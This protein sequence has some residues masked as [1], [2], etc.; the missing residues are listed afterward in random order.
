MSEILKIELN[1][2]YESVLLVKNLTVRWLST[3]LS[4]LRIKIVMESGTI[5]FGRFKRGTKN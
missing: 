4:S 2:S 5:G 3:A 1:Y